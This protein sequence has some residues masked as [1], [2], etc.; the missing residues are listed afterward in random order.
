MMWNNAGRFVNAKNSQ[1]VIKHAIIA[2]NHDMDQDE[3]DISPDLLPDSATTAPTIL[4][5]QLLTITRFASGLKVQWCTFAQM[6]GACGCISFLHAIFLNSWAFFYTITVLA[7]C[8]IT[9][10]V[11]YFFSGAPKIGV[12]N[13]RTRTR[14]RN[15]YNNL[16]T[17]SRSR[18]RYTMYNFCGIHT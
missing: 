4:P 15:R 5:P 10:I 16:H 8:Q 17:R 11:L 3:D 14:R 2:T 9:K 18:D 7:A 12:A 1:S 6:C 13:L